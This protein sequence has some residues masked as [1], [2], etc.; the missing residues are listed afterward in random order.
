LL[1][2]NLGQLLVDKAERPDVDVERARRLLNEAEQVLRAA[3]REESPKGLRRHVHATRDRLGALRSSLPPRRGPREEAPEP[4]REP[5]AG[6]VLQ[7]RVRSL[8]AFGAFVSLPGCG[9]GLLHKS[10]IAHEPIDDPAQA[11]E[12]GQ[13]IEVK[14]MEVSRKEG[15]LRIALSRRA[16]LPKPEGGPPQRAPARP[17]PQGNRPRE[18]RGRGRRDD[19]RRGQD[20]N[21]SRSRPR[22]RDDDKLASLGE[23]LLA[24]I[25]QQKKDG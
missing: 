7:G 8:A 11:L 4:E 12:V 3:L 21:A 9:T 19:D 5:E 25:N 16:L 24:K 17:Q 14:V 23:M 15:K 6:E 22:S 13:E 10:E 2:H 18:D 20:R 1:L